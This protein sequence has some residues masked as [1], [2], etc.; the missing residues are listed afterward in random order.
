MRRGRK[1]VEKRWK[2]MEKRW[3]RDGIG[4]EEEM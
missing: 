1:E 2:R 3:K 4:G